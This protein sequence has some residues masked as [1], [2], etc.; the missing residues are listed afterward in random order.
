MMTMIAIQTFFS[1]EVIYIL[2]L[3]KLHP[4]FRHEQV[5]RLNVELHLIGL[6][7]GHGSV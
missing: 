1:L 6:I 4:Q 3:D 2:L 7:D 5:S